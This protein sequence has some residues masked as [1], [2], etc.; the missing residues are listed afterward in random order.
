MSDDFRTDDELA[1]A[2]RRGDGNAFAELVRR[3]EARLRAFVAGEPAWAADH[4]KLTQRVWAAIDRAL[5]DG[6]YRGS[7]FRAWLFKSTEAV[8]G[9]PAGTSARASRLTICFDRLAKAQP[10]SH[11]L[12][13]CVSHGLN[14]TFV[15]RKH[16]MSKAKLR[17]RYCVAI[18]AVRSCL[19]KS[20][21][22]RGLHLERMPFDSAKLPRWLER[23]LTGDHLGELIEELLAV[24]PKRTP[25]DFA[26]W[27]APL[28]DHILTSGLTSVPRSAIRKLFTNP[29]A[30]RLLQREVLTTGGQYWDQVPR[31][32]GFT[33]RLAAT[34]PARPRPLAL[35]PAPPTPQPVPTADAPPAS[36]PNRRRLSRWVIVAAVVAAVLLSG[37][38]V[39][40]VLALTGPRG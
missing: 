30:L 31:S 23:Y 2:H 19:V 22:G 25:F 14:R 1:R 11:R 35:P 4:G 38:G 12:V 17:D 29:P 32:T 34:R 15:A 5:Q 13:M 28:R 21:H 26:A 9:T 33:R 27:F 20:G 3:H 18:S 6:K 16:R 24:R 8:A 37:L 39:F 40:A 36:P 7:H 10:E